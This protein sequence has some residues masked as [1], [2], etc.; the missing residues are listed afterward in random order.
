M[1][2]PGDMPERLGL[3]HQQLLARMIHTVTSCWDSKKI[4]P[5]EGGGESVEK[6]THSRQVLKYPLAQNVSSPNVERASKSW[7][8]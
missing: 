7:F 1:P 5:G 2:D 3:V 8:C 6:T 4:V